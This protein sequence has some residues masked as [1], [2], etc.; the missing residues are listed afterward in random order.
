ML[1]GEIAFKNNIYYY[2]FAFRSSL[3]VD[4]ALILKFFLN[5]NSCDFNA[6]FIS[7]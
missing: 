6:T 2:Y 4:Y 1:S 3:S 7:R 5:I